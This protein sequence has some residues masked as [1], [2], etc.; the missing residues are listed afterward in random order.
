[1]WFTVFLPEPPMPTTLILANDSTS[2]LICGICFLLGWAYL[3]QW[4]WKKKA[5]DPQAQTFRYFM[6]NLG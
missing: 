4:L 5:I 3:T 6:E 1:M 2:G